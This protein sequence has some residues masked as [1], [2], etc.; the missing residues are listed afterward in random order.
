MTRRPL[1]YLH[2]LA[3][4]PQAHK[5][6]VLAARLAP[7]G[8]PLIAPDLNVPSFATLTLTAQVAAVEAA[9]RPLA[10]AHGP[11]PVVG[12]SLGALV[13]L[14]LHD[15]AP[16]LV[17][18]LA[19]IAPALGFVGDRLARALG[20]DLATWQRQGYLPM[21]HFGDGQFHPLGFSLVADAST[22][23]FAALAV[24]ARLLIVHGTEDELIPVA[25]SAAFAARH[26]GAV[27]M[28]IEG[29][30]HSLND[31]LDEVFAAV[32][33]FFGIG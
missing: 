25:A 22:Y 12:S 2:G 5:A 7:H 9:L 13:A 18:E 33:D 24:P 14:I 28:P 6:R 4:T 21:L 11:I 19:L 8:I 3:S 31:R 32:F 20:A 26:P 23:D 15:R 29:G 10:R 30:N 16:D 17:S 27:F 1:A